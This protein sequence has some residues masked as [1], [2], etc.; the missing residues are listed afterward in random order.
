MLP[1]GKISVDVLNVA[2]H[3][4]VCRRSERNRHAGLLWL[5]HTARCGSIHGDNPAS[6]VSICNTSLYPNPAR[7]TDNP[8]APDR[9]LRYASK[10]RNMDQL[11]PLDPQLPPPI[12]EGNPV[13]A[14]VYEP[15]T[16]PPSDPWQPIIPPQDPRRQDQ[17]APV[18]PN[19]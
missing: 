3:Y 12:E 11:D 4:I 5:P 16:P 17:D 8:C 15:S 2:T 7:W 19:Y 9:P 14:P 6:R 13:P 18:F 10:G 1:Y